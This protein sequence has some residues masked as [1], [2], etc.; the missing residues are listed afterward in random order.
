MQ[1]HQHVTWLSPML[2]SYH[3]CQV[4]HM[5]ELCKLYLLWLYFLWLY[6]LR[7]GTWRSY[8]SY[9]YYGSTSYGSTY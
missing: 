9:T 2:P 4:R 8:A 3:P 6:L 7:C 5:E 1:A